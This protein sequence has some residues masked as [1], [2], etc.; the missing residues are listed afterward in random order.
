MRNL[1]VRQR[2]YRLE[3]TLSSF[4][5]RDDLVESS[6]RELLEGLDLYYAAIYLDDR[7]HGSLSVA[8]F[9]VNEVSGQAVVRGEHHFSSVSTTVEKMLLTVPAVQLLIESGDPN[10]DDLLTESGFELIVVI[11]GDFDSRGCI[12]LGVKRSEEPFSNDEKE[13]VLVLA[14]EMELA[15]KNLEMAASLIQQAQELKRLSRRL[16]DVQE[17]ERSRL[18]RDLHD[19][20]GQALTALKISLE[21]TRNEL[22]EDADHAK[23]RLN[24]ALK[25]TE[26]TMGKLRTIAR[27]LRPPALDSIGL[28]AALE[29]QCIGFTK[30][31]RILV[32][33]SGMDIPDISDMASICL[34]R[35]LQEGLTNCVKHGKATRVEVNL[36][37][38]GQD[39]ELSI[40][41]NGKGFEPHIKTVAH[42]EGGIGLIDIRERLEALE[43]NFKISSEPG[44]GT[45]L[46]ASI[47]LED[48]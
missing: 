35:V 10:T 48:K 44:N 45:R 39:I 29:G 24:D 37:C 42:D 36:L 7:P 31:T 33:Y 47:P 41:D 25:L 5:D 12:A 9:G 14:A 19:D 18:S 46:I 1:K 32:M 38:R 26:E 3:R 8:W 21:L 40:V 4:R 34:Y 11:N 27:G 2:L 43:G 16:I 30:R 22:A 28:N 23:E 20:S 15:L 17:S 13:R 6:G